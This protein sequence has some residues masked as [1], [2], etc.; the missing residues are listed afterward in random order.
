MF[1]NRMFILGVLMVSGVTVNTSAEKSQ[2]TQEA[3]L[4]TTVQSMPPIAATDGAVA[5]IVV[6][7]AVGA[8]NA[9]GTF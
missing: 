3:V 9:A 1:I 7:H 4:M 5:G 2:A 8:Y 6:D